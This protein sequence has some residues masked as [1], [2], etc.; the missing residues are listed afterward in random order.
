MRSILIAGALISIATEAAYSCSTGKHN[1]C[2]PNG[3]PPF[4]LG[5]TCV[6]VSDVVPP[7]PVPPALPNPTKLKPSD[8]VKSAFPGADLVLEAA[9]TSG[10]QD[11][12][13]AAQNFQA[14]GAKFDKEMQTAISNALTNPEKSI[15][16]AVKTH[17]K[18]ANDIVDAVHASVRYAQRTVDGYRDGLSRAGSRIREGKVVD[19]IWHLGTDKLAVDN[20]NAAKFMQE[21][22]QARQAAQVVASTSGGPAGAAAFAAWWAYNSSG[23]NVEAALRAGAYTYAV[24]EGY[25]QVNTMPAATATEVAKKAAAAA[26][27]R[28]IAIAAAGGNR[29]DILNAAAQGG[30][31][32]IVQAGQAYV[33]KEYVDPA[34]AKSDTFCMDAVKSSCAD[35]KQ[36]L[37]DSRQRL[38]EYRS[39][40]DALANTIV[41]DDRNWMISWDSKVLHDRDSSAPGVVLTYIGNGSPYDEQKLLLAEIGDSAKFKHP[42]IESTSWAALRDPGGASSYFDRISPTGAG[43]PVAPDDVLIAKIHVNIRP[44]PSGGGWGDPIDVITPGET[45][46][47]LEVKTANTNIG[48]QEWVRFDRLQE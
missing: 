45:I 25:A 17:V 32:V 23:H 15:N 29:E 6:C 7:V 5:Q 9:R 4:N 38:E 48:P 10:N 24:S 3:V 19:A 44:G 36:W 11:L 27:I 46:K 30:G 35:A 31:S 16:D 22:E 47:V 8:V 40:A 37:E 39:S 20:Q 18:A 2:V 33:T 14:I 1:Q 28:G 42:V 43:S 12:I 26:S 34:K 21:S 41:T 13:A